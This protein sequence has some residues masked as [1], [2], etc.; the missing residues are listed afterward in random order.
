MKR[1]PTC[2]RTYDDD[3]LSFCLEDGTPLAREASARPDSEATLVTPSPRPPGEFAVGP[4]V[5][6][7]PP[8]VPPLYPVPGGP[9]T[10]RKVWPWVLAIGGVLFLGL[11]VIV[12]AVMIVSQLN[13]S[14]SPN[15]NLPA[16]SPTPI[17]SPSVED[18]PSPIASPQV[19]EGDDVPTDEDEVLADLKDLENEWEQA[20]V[21]GDKEALDRILAEEYTGDSNRSKQEYLNSIKPNPGR[22]WRYSDFELELDGA[23][24]VLTGR[25]DRITDEGTTSYTFVDTYV[26]RDHR[27]Q[28]T[29]SRSTRLQ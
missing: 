10:Q 15:A 20:N 5:V 27:W 28:A 4:T 24:A 22:K 6:A 18:Y 29:G 12:A 11:V 19:Y 17:A 25:L 8:Q 21:A 26:W 2:Q 1:C 13:G 16:P 23:R 3:T 9:P 7:V 14:S